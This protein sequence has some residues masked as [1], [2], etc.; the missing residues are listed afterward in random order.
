[1][2]NEKWTQFNDNLKFEHENQKEFWD[3]VKQFEQDFPI[4]FEKHIGKFIGT[5][6]III[7]SK[8]LYLAKIGIE[9]K[10]KILPDMK[11]PDDVQSIDTEHTIELSIEKRWD[12]VN[13]FIGNNS[14]SYPEKKSLLFDNII[15]EL[16]ANIKDIASVPFVKFGL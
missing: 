14:I 2:R 7:I 12:G 13:V 15:D 9:F 6:N 10:L 8:S 11:S 4:D 16:I 1:M 3:I 5:I